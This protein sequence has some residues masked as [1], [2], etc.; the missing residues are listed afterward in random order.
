MQKF[1]KLLT[2]VLAVTTGASALGL[3]ACGDQPQQSSSA[4]TH[5]FGEWSAVE[6][7]NCEENVFRRV[8]EEC[9]ET[10]ER[11]GTFEDHDFSAYGYNAT[12]HWSICDTCGEAK[13]EEERH[14]NDGQE[15]CKICKTL[16][17]TPCVTYDLSADGSYATVTG[18]DQAETNILII[19]ST[20]NGVPVTAIA[21]G[22]FE[23]CRNLA[24][25][26]LPDGLTSIG[27]NAFNGCAKLMGIYLKKSVTSVGE[28]AFG[29]C[30]ELLIFYEGA[31]GDQVGWS[32]SWNP[33]RCYVIWNY[34]G[35]RAAAIS[36]RALRIGDSMLIEEDQD[37]KQLITNAD[38]GGV[39]APEGFS[40]LTRF[41]AKVTGAGTPWTNG[42]LWEYNYN[43]MQLTGYE[44]VWFA[45]KLVNAYWAFVSDGSKNRGEPWLYFHL[46]NKG[47][48]EDGF[49]RWDIEASI[50]GQV[51]EKL[52]N[53]S[54]RQLDME[55]P[56]DSISRLL[57][58]EGFS[59]EG[60]R[61]I[62]IYPTF[63]DGSKSPTIY[64]TEILGIKK[65]V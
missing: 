19:S 31:E 21:D 9:T 29:G 46:T 17:P 20:Y 65:S 27:A 39:K 45:A 2:A 59:S 41:D 54:G 43:K 23:N 26:T 33:E 57:W 8:C 10:Q 52:E 34:V 24:Q 60:K 61:A 16:I 58:S 56:T 49:T 32:E 35:E 7:K 13:Q 53:Q 11:Q 48:D 63:P 14:I 42:V 62:L 36:M 40:E 3:S 22:A 55:R 50:G 30:S 6:D 18:Y 47:P 51:Y 38:L 15:G 5:S 25:I 4:H 37:R 44:E 12:H 1:K 64:C 28:N